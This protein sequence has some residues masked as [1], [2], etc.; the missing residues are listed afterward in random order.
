M[1]QLILELSVA[2]E[3]TLENFVVGRNTEAVQA[4]R[5]LASGEACSR[6]IYLWG[7]S[8]CGRSHL[9]KAT[10]SASRTAALTVVDGIETLTRA[11]AEALFPVARDALAGTGFL[12]ASGDI[13]PASLELREDLRSRLGAGLVYRLWPLS[14]GEKL[15]ALRARAHHLGFELPPD[16]GTYLLRH[17][18]RDMAALLSTLD[19]LDRLSVK[20]Q[21]SITLPLLRQCLDEHRWPAIQ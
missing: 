1:D 2:P 14:D 21:R 5:A 18:P 6:V 16:A 13:P 9:L 20:L 19:A 17:C 8:G 7:E 11:Q 4:L 15:A 12:L 3:P 10:L